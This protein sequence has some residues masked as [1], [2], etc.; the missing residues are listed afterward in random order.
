MSQATTGD[1][2]RNRIRVRGTQ[3]PAALCVQT[4]LCG[5]HVVQRDGF[6][7]ARELRKRWIVGV[8]LIA[9]RLP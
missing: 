2:N 8:Q 6:G 9:S 3:C 5:L 4:A 7:A 1:I